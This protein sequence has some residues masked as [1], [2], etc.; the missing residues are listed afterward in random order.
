MGASKSC[1]PTGDRMYRH[2]GEAA[3]PTGAVKALGSMGRTG[4]ARHG[5]DSVDA[6]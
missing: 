4:D 2:V 6:F 1:R 5:E 3:S